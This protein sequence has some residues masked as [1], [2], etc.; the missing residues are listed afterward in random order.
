MKKLCFM[1]VSNE[2]MDGMTIEVRDSSGN[3][4]D[5]FYLTT[6]SALDLVGDIN[7]HIRN[8]VSNHH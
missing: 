6:R 3:V 5:N 4:I 1:K 7:T 2:D 8:Q